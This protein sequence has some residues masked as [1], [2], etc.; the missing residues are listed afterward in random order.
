VDVLLEGKVVEDDVLLVD[1]VDLC[2]CVFGYEAMND[3]SALGKSMVC[4]KVSGV[5]LMAVI[6]ENWKEEKRSDRDYLDGLIGGRE[7]RKTGFQS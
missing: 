5:V 1:S 2:V 4:G 7:R 3:D 6:I